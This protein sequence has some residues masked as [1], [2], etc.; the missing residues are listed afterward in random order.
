MRIIGGSARGHPLQTPRGRSTRPTTDRVREALFSILEARDVVAGAAA[1]E[2]YAGSGA[3]GLEALSRGAASATFVES[4]VPCQRVIRANIERLGFEP[5]ATLLRMRVD[6]ALRLLA[7]RGETFQLVLADPPYAE[8]P[9]PLLARVAASGLLDP[10]GLLVLEHDSRRT[11]D[12]DGGALS[13][14]FCRIYGDTA[15]SIYTQDIDQSTGQDSR[16]S[17]A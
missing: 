9:V 2:L 1:L 13:L 8:D 6:P 4:A 12:P 11:P 10:A 17:P 14:A 5:R 15:L 3:L 7:R 16:Q